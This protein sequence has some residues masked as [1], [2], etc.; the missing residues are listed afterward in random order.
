M[1]NSVITNN[2]LGSVILGDASFRDDVLTL[3]GAQT[4]LEGTILARDSGT[5]KLVLFVKGGVSNENGIPKVILPFE[6][7]STGAGDFPVRVGV[8]G[9]YRK[10]RL[11]IDADG[12]DSNIDSVV[13]D[14]LRN[15]GLTPIDVQELNILDNQTFLPSDLAGLQLW[16]DAEDLSTITESSGAVS[17]WND[18]SGNGQ[19]AAQGIGSAQPTTGSRTLNG[20]NAIDFDGS[21]EYMD[22]PFSSLL[23]PSAFTLYM[24]CSSD[25]IGGGF[26]SP[27][28]SRVINP[29]KGYILYANTADFWQG[30]TGSGGTFS[31]T[32]NVKA[33]V[34]DETVIIAYTGI[35]NDQKLFVNGLFAGGAGGGY[36]EN[37]S[38]DTRIGAGTSEAVPPL[39][40]F[41]GL[42]TECLLYSDR[43]SAVQQNIIK[44]YLGRTG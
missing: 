16:L 6:V 34:A 24:V 33:V 11:V 18:K 43:H 38:S 12:D 42:I 41:N 31:V 30:W 14:Q 21:A 17:Q 22:I 28:T 3:G 35:T 40:F 8:A 39:F 29:N 13:T 20:R 26:K 19:N 9:E 27:I 32:S 10:E 4:V 15:Y 25:I 36:L 5:D 1:A 7:I 37:T 44:S 23:N 2:D